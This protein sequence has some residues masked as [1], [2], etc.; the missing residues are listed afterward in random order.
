MSRSTV[1]EKCLRAYLHIGQPG[2]TRADKNETSA[3]NAKHGV[4]HVATVSKKILEDPLRKEIQN[5]TTKVIKLHENNTLRLDEIRILK[6]T[7]YRTYM[8][9]IPSILRELQTKIDE[10]CD[11]I[12]YNAAIDRQEARMKG[13]F[14]RKD[15]YSAEEMKSNL[16]IEFKIR[17]LGKLEGFAE[18]FDDSNL[19]KELEEQAELEDNKAVKEAD[20]EAWCR[21]Y[22]VANH[23]FE[24][25]K[26]P[27]KRLL[28][29]QFDK[30]KEMAELLP[31][32]SPTDDPDLKA[33]A[34]ELKSKVAI[35]DPDDLKYDPENRKK[36]AETT[37]SILDKMKG[38]I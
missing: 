18:V 27:D 3:T 36:I 8:S 21:L 6:A 17:P 29:V 13:L 10:F 24:Q 11:P 15:F 37:E 2:N 22:A 14:N 12:Y 9:L 16:K 25:L 33:V 26:D 23:L 1:Y 30:V 31:K 28:Q 7:H 19:V 4:S 20:K 34:D 38:F 5:L 32:L 35:I